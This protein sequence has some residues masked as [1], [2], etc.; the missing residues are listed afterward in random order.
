M[1]ESLSVCGPGNEISYSYAREDAFSC[2]TS[3][4]LSYEFNFQDS[5]E[6][7][8]RVKMTTQMGKLK[9]S[10]SERVVSYESFMKRVTQDVSWSCALVNE[11]E[12]PV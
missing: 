4:S 1:L 9:K 8:F 10:Y 3:E 2:N 7:H 6:I 5:N 11:N 12:E